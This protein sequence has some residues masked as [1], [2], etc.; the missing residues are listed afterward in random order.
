MADYWLKLYIEIL[1]DPKMQTLPDRLWRRI[2]EIFLIGKRMG[3]DGWIP[4]IR[5]LAWMLRM[6]IEDLSHDMQQIEATGIIVPAIN[7]W[8]IPNFLKRQGPSDAAERKRQQRE[9]EHSRQYYGI[10]T[11]ES[12]TVTQKTEDREQK[13]EAE[14]R[15]IDTDFSHM[16]VLV[17]NK[18]HCNEFAGGAERWTKAV[19]ELMVL[20]PDECD[21]DAGLKWMFDNNRAVAGP[22]SIVNPVAI[23]KNKRLHAN[24]NGSK[25]KRDY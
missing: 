24:G 9:R 8:F 25:P 5:Q 22:W 17:A 11:D 20:S 1:D 15:D 7:G 10:V 3:K 4:D 13:T 19:N 16:S 12:R 14:K 21:I 23:E 2:I 6:P 18:L